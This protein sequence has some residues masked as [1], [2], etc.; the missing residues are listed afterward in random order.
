M[1]VIWTS[2]RIKSLPG[3]NSG[4]SIVPYEFRRKVWEHELLERVRRFFD[5]TSLCF[6]KTTQLVLFRE[7]KLDYMQESELRQRFGP[8]LMDIIYSS[9]TKRTDIYFRAYQ[10]VTWPHTFMHT[11]LVC[12]VLLLCHA[13]LR[14]MWFLKEQREMGSIGG[15]QT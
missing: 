9:Q 1:G 4:S 2:P 3:S 11:A 15:M 10:P 12:S 13:L 14:Y 7:D 8:S 5:D 6:E